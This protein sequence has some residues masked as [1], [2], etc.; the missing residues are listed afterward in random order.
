MPAVP[1]RSENRS[2]AHESEKGGASAP[3]LQCPRDICDV[4]LWPLAG[5]KRHRARDRKNAVPQHRR[6]SIQA[7]FASRQ[8]CREAD[9]A[10]DKSADKGPDGACSCWQG[11]DAGLARTSNCTTRADFPNEPGMS[12]K[13]KHFTFWNWSKPGMFM[14]INKLS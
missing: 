4:L 1:R 13:G 9:Y 6:D 10:P 5:S 14:K 3:P 11:R 2:I 8:K 12:M 7:L